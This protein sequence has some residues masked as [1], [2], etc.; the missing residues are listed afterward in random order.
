M[1]R[2]SLVSL[3][4]TGNGNKAE[5]QNSSAPYCLFG[6]ATICIRFSPSFSLF[7][8]H[9]VVEPTLLVR[10]QSLSLRTH[11]VILSLIPV[12]TTLN[13]LPHIQAPSGKYPIHLPLQDATIYDLSGTISVISVVTD[14]CSLLLGALVAAVLSILG[15]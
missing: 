11:R 15:H 9:H 6:G 7:N 14:A 1:L 4:F 3:Q 10:G 13:R 8:L 12:G 2:Y 5:T